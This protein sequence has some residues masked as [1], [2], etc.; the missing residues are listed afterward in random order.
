MRYLETVLLELTNY[1]KTETVSPVTLLNFGFDIAYLEENLNK[2]ILRQLHHIEKTTTKTLNLP[3]A[4]MEFV[5]QKHKNAPNTS[6]TLTYKDNNGKY[7]V[8]FLSELIRERAVCV[9]E[10]SRIINQMA[11]KYDFNPEIRQHENSAG[12]SDESTAGLEELKRHLG[13]A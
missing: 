7:R 10:I 12:E 11:R 3:L 4:I 5:F 8:V 9:R 2:G 13:K 1:K 6:R